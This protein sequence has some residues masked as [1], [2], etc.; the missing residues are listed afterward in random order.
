MLQTF[1]EYLKEIDWLYIS[2]MVG[3]SLVVVGGQ[4]IFF[5]HVRKLFKKI[6]N[7]FI[8][9]KGK[10]DFKDIKIL[11]YTLI[12]PARLLHICFFMSRVTMYA[13][14]IASFYI[15][16]TLLFSIFPGT[17]KIALALF[18]GVWGPFYSIVQSVIAYIPNLLRIAVIVVVTR[19]FVKFMKVISK[20]ISAERLV[21][22][23][24]YS[25]WA[26]AT[27]NLL[28]FL[29]YAFMIVMIFPLLPNSESATFKGVSV[30]LG[31]LISLGSTTVVANV[32]AGLVLTYMRS[33]KLGD[34]VKVGEVLG[35]VVEK[36]PFAIRIRTNKKEVITVPNGTLLSSNVT[37]YSTAGDEKTGVIISMPISVCYNV[38]WRRAVELIIEAAR[39]TD[40]VLEQPSPFVFVS[41]LGDNAT[42]MELYIYTNEPEKQ[43]RIFSELNKNIRD[44]FE[45]D[46]IDLT[47]PQQ[48][49]I[50]GEAKVAPQPLQL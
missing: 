26:H 28:R 5:L 40:G 14:Y 50:Q 7:P 37:N 41:N 10:N 34:R 4:V 43:P 47:V 33:F 17:E 42:D 35:D 11:N 1:L 25:D 21:I 38:P 27:F 2:R 16:L 23:G 15:S 20:E 32:V 9:R 24:F 29:S 48:I 13:I 12:T 39:K 22:P 18:R 46:G 6:I 45:A 8:I 31:V 44:L 19:Y 30:F 49:L 36:T 3:L